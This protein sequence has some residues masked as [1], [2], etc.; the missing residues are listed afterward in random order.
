MCSGRDR[1]F[2]RG[3]GRSGCMT[4]RSHLLLLTL[5]VLVPLSL[6]GI[7]ATLWIT[8]REREVFEQ[9]ARERTLA[10]VTAVDTELR[11]HADRLRALASSYDLQVGDLEG[12]RREVMRVL[13]T[14]SDWRDV[15][16]S[17]PGGEVQLRAALPV[18]V[19][20][21]VSLPDL[22]TYGA[23]SGG[24]PAF[25]N[26]ED[27]GGEKLFNVRIP[28]ETMG[29]PAILS[30]LITPESI[31]ALLT[32][33]R[34]PADWVGV[35]LDANQNIVARTLNHRGML[36]RPASESLRQALGVAS[37]GWFHGST[38]ENFE[39]YTPYNRSPISG[40]AVALGIPAHRVEGTTDTSLAVLVVGLLAAN[41]V[42]LLFA[43]LYS[44]RIAR[45][46]AS[47]AS[48]ARALGEG[49]RI[50]PP[51]EARFREVREVSQALLSSAQAIGE[52]EEKLRAADQAKDEFL[53]MLGHELR[54]PLGAL[55]SASQVLNVAEPGESAARDA[56]SV[57]SRQLERM[58]R[59]VDDLLDVGRVI[60]GKVSLQRAPTDLA[61]VVTQVVEN[62]RRGGFFKQRDVKVDVSPVWINGDE[63]RIEQ[64]VFNLLENAGKYTPPDGRISIRVFEE[65]G[66]AV[67][68]VADSGI[69][70]SPELLPRVFDLFSQGQRSIDRGASGLGIGLTL[71]KRLTEMHG[72]SV[73]AA[74]AGSDLGSKFRLQL[75]T[76]PPPV[77]SA[78]LAS[79]PIRISQL[80]RVLL[81]EDNDDARRS[82]VTIL[83]YYGYRVFEAADGFEGIATAEEI[84]PDCAII[85]IGLPQYD[86][87]E[88]AKRL[89]ASPICR[90]MLLIALTGYGSEN[91]RREAEAAG[92]DDYLV[93][94]VSPQDLAELIESKLQQRNSH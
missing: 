5:V 81:I 44:R 78:S 36:G 89:R 65:D 9:G 84:Q 61:K 35:V 14:Q 79:D 45:P 2:P 46:I 29:A 83:R 93:K 90:N 49:A 25:G 33:Q 30:A 28:V 73:T 40:W 57:I 13:P 56:T 39:V 27:H 8:D 41:I 24:E 88:V 19:A 48:A 42:A 31:L 94:P 20:R 92:F 38:I 66:N 82:M 80:R 76:I 1:T 12:F 64:I 10:L 53:A 15:I 68:E 77:Q 16:L 71:V 34:L 69:G 11:G 6:F 47:L 7:G 22:A 62:L 67:F 37:E 21:P 86:G 58:T 63:T 91:A 70:M 32:P 26:L 18:E 87:Y 17:S 74:S 50:R 75:P 54:N 3:A 85:D 55:S 59:L 43:S 51:T 23:V 52:R 72:G 60:S 4:L